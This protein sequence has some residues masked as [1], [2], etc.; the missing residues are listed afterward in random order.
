MH[1]A[2]SNIKNKFIFKKEILI[3]SL[4]KEKLCMSEA[5][6]KYL[7]LIFIRAKNLKYQ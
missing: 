2:S 6:E 3:N 7:L 4:F 5:N 1:Y